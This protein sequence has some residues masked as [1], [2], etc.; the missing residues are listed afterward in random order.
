MEN[1]Y[2]KCKNVKSKR[3][4][5]LRCPNTATHGDYCGIHHKHP[6]PWVES[7]TKEKRI[8]KKQVKAVKALEASTAAY[9]IQK[10]FKMYIG[11][12]HR[13]KHG[14]AYYVRTMC[15]NDTDFFSTEPIAD[16]SGCMFFSYIDTKQHVHAFDIRSIATLIEKAQESAVIENPF[17]RDHIPSHVVNKV[18]ALVKKLKA[19]NIST[20]WAKLDPETPIQQYR[21]KVVDI[22]AMIDELNYYSSPDWFLNL[23]NAQHAKFYKQ[24]YSIWTYR[25]NLSEDQ[26]Q[27]IVPNYKNILFRCSPYISAT[28]TV[29]RI[30]KLNLNTIRSLITSAV[31]R[32][33]RIIGAMYVVSTL[34]LVCDEAKLAYPWLY[35]SVLVDDVIVNHDVYQHQFPRLPTLFGAGG[36]ISHIFNITTPPTPPILL[37]PPPQHEE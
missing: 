7:I 4:H 30:Q 3:D 16:I 24:L 28:Y 19:R 36:W 29:E 25:A 37:L 32:N 6:Q 33:D 9:R 31:D 12:Y 11:L 21:M 34:T 23:T 35:E 1:S 5:K 20:E 14:P 27:L 26:K 22:F 10:W 13:R 18:K 15:V 17:T 2:S 8:A